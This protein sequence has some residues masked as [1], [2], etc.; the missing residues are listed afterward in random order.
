MITNIYPYEAERRLEDAKKILI[1]IERENY[2]NDLRQLIMNFLEQTKHVLFPLQTFG[3]REKLNNFEYWWTKK[4]DVLKK[5]TVS[6]YL[7]GLRNDIVKSC[8]DLIGIDFTYVSPGRTIRGPMQLGADGLMFGS[9]DQFNIPRWKHT[10]NKSNFKIN[11]W[12]FRNLPPELQDHNSIDLLKIHIN[13][14]E[15]IISDYIATYCNEKN[16]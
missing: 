3:K 6:K 8:E 9:Y 10:E 5:N 15:V 13:N 7:Y 2:P 1:G 4:I 16:Y 12:Y 14:L 11:K